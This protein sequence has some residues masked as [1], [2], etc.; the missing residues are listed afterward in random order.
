MNTTFYTGTQVCL[1][2]ETDKD[3]ETHYVCHNEGITGKYRLCEK[4]TIKLLTAG[5]QAQSLLVCSV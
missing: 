3:P 5:L 4:T 1:A 2:L